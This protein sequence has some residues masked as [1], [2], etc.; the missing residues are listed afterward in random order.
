MKTAREWKEYRLVDSGDGEKLEY[1]GDWLLARPDPQAIWPKSAPE[2]WA[3]AHGWYHRSGEGGGH[4]EWRAALPHE[5]EIHW[6]DLAFLVR[7]TDFKHTGL[8]PEQAV[9]WDWMQDA[10]RRAGRPVSILNLFAYTGAA[11]VACIAAGAEVC[12]VDAAKGMVRWAERNLEINGLRQKPLR[13]IVDDVTAFVRREARRGRR[14]DAIIMDPPSYGRGSQGETWKIGRDLPELLVACRAV[15]SANPLFVQINGYTAGY[16][17][18][19]Y[20]NLL[21]AII[22]GAGRS[23]CGEIGLASESGLVLPCGIYARWLPAPT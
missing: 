17:A 6:R 2:K 16:P 19:V 9:N 7:P 12:H 20:A 15:L 13:L 18:T 1:W 22:G 5:W 8:F 21:Q 10:I 3:A 4:W 14:Y 11:T 23:E